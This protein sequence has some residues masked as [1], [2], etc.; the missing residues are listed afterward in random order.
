MS[1]SPSI[2]S[3]TSKSFRRPSALERRSI[4]A[5]FYRQQFYFAAAVK[6]EDFMEWFED[7]VRQLAYKK[8]NPNGGPDP[9][10]TVVKIPAAYLRLISQ[11]TMEITHGQWDPGHESLRRESYASRT[12]DEL[13]DELVKY[14]GPPEDFRSKI[15]TPILQRQLQAVPDCYT[16]S[17]RHAIAPRTNTPTL[18]QV[19]QFY[20]GD[21]PLD[22]GYI[23][24]YRRSAIYFSEI[25]WHLAIIMGRIDVKSVFSYNKFLNDTDLVFSALE[26]DPHDNISS[27]QK[28]VADVESAI[29]VF[30]AAEVRLLVEEELE[31]FFAEELERVVSSFHLL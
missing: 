4:R 25:R 15:L 24:S 28:T 12:L 7:E 18:E 1:C 6:Q 2:R 22:S 10:W 13:G 16:P 27:S 14:N 5:P 3:N 9:D 31:D 30:T 17:V 26:I 8:R 19:T 29:P 21:D 11:L 23:P 20:L